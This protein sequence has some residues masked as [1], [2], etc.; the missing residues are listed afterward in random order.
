MGG[1]ERS[2]GVELRG[3]RKTPRQRPNHKQVYAGNI[4]EFKLYSEDSRR[5]SRV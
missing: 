1:N 2:S 5:A 3:W 4:R